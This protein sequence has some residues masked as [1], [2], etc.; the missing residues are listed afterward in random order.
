MHY[1]AMIAPHLS[2]R[3]LVVLD[4]IYLHRDMWD[5]W[6]A[7]PLKFRVAIAINRGR[8]GLL[9]F[10]DGGRTGKRVD[11]SSYTGWWLVGGVRE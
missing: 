7:I 10:A 11:L 9:M 6:C 1:L 2:P 8:F 4:D 3:S 5:A